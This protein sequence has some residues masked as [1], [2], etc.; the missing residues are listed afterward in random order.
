MWLLSLFHS[1][2]GF[3]AVEFGGDILDACSIEELVAAQSAAKVEVVG[4]CTGKWFHLV[5]V[6]QIVWVLDN[7]EYFPP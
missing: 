2:L 3:K 6:T 7:I 1:I 5:I 4:L